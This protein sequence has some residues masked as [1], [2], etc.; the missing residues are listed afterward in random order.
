MKSS[1][2]KWAGIKITEIFKNSRGF[3]LVQVMVSVGIMSGLALMMMTLMEN[4]AKQQKT[5]ELKSEQND[6]KAIIKQVIANNVACDATFQGMSPGEEIKEIRTTDD[7]SVPPFAETGVKFKS[8]N[9]Y[10]KKMVLLTRQE[11]LDAK[12]RVP[13]TPP[14]QYNDPEGKGFGFGY[15]RI[16]FVKNIGAV[17]DSNKSHQFY[18]ARETSVDIPI[19]GN[20]YDLELVKHTDNKSIEE[21]CV[22]RAKAK[23]INCTAG[24][25]SDR[26][27]FMAFTGSGSSIQD[28]ASSQSLYLGECRF[29]RDDSPFIY[30]VNQ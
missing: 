5:I 17:T 22:E 4:Q 8:A 20:F 28:Q 13:G 21:S 30:C 11:E 2:V 27:W 23:G 25:A 15:L 6:I 1:Q 18:G 3:S 9:V 19:A 14:I 24:D 10:I 26:C 29:F 7:Q 12:L 16:T